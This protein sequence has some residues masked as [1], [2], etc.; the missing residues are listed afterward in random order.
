MIIGLLVF[1]PD[2]HQDPSFVFG[3]RINNSGLHD[4]STAASA[5]GSWSCRWAS[6]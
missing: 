2:N 4:G 3:E 1:V 6:C 5:S